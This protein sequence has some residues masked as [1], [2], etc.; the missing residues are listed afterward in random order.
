MLGRLLGRLF[1]ILLLVLLLNFPAWSV[2]GAA[3]GLLLWFNVVL[4]TLS[5]FII[6]TQVIVALDGVRLMM[7]PF[8]PIL[9]VLFGLSVQGAYVMLCGMLCGYPLGARLCADFKERGAISAEEADYLLAICNHPSPM[10]LLGY[11]M[12]QIPFKLSPVL[13][14]TCLYLPI[15]PISVLA[16]RIYRANSFGDPNSRDPSGSVR[17][18]PQ[19]SSTCLEDIIHS[20]CETMVLIGGY[21]MLFSILAAWIEHLDLLPPTLRVSLIGAAEITT[22]VHALC[23]G[24]PTAWVLPAVVAAVAFGGFSG[25]FQTKSVIKNAGLSIRHYVLWKILHACLSCVILT[26]LLSCLP[27]LR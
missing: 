7:I 25:I 16:R 14:F 2:Q 12:A 23:A 4:P 9:H 19:E 26:V 10:F 17:S 3:N 11:V 15:L 13:L 5:P 18:D 6:C 27:R 20:T 21:I 8:Y 1:P 24:L 22:G